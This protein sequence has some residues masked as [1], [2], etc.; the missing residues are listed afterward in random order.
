MTPCCYF[1]PSPHSDACLSFHS[2]PFLPSCSLSSSQHWKLNLGLSLIRP[3]VT[4]H[5]CSSSGSKL[6]TSAWSFSCS[7]TGL[8]RVFGQ[9]IPFASYLQSWDDI[10][11]ALGYVR[12]E[13]EES[14]SMIITTLV[15]NHPNPILVTDEYYLR[16]PTHVFCSAGTSDTL[17][18]LWI[19]SEPCCRPL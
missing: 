4:F 8:S 16:I 9:A 2:V 19:V 15:A 18:K 14:K 7:C 3:P 10:Y 11:R 17:E 12:A 1:T 13:A 5:C 6:F